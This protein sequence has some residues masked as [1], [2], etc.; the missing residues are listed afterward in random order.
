MSCQ[1]SGFR[2]GTRKSGP[3]GCL[4][5]AHSFLCGNPLFLSTWGEVGLRGTEV[6]K[7]MWPAAAPPAA[8]NQWQRQTQVLTAGLGR[9][10]GD[11]AHP[12]QAPGRHISQH[13]RGTGH[14]TACKGQ[15][16]V[17][18]QAGTLD[19]VQLPWEVSAL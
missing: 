17:R 5:A 2:L 18:P 12:A 9:R 4:P 15:C 7:H 16:G 6:A 3:S 14:S 1:V 10:R 8:G 19:G 13:L 11:H